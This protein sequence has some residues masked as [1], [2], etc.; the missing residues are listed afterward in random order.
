MD[1]DIANDTKFSSPMPAIGLYMAV[2]TLVC[3]ILMLCD[4]F[5]AIL[6]KKPWIPCRFFVLNSFTLTLLSIATKLPSDLTTSMP[7]ACD[8]LSKL[9]GTSLMC[10]SIGFFRPSTVNMSQ[11][12]LS[13]NLAS[14][15][16]MVITIV[17]NVSLQ[18]STGAIFLFKLENVIVLVLML[19]LL[20]V[21]GTYRM[22]FSDYFT[23]P[24]RK[25]L[26]HMP[27][28]VYTLKRCYVHSYITDP[29]LTL[30]RLSSSATVGVLCTICFAVLSEAAVRAFILDQGLK[31]DSDY[32]WSIWVVVGLQLITLLVGTL[33]NVCRGLALASQMHS[34]I[35]I[36][37]TRHTFLESQRVFLLTHRNWNLY[38]KTLNRSRMVFQI[39]RTMENI[40]DSLLFLMGIWAESVNKLILVPIRMVKEFFALAMEKINTIDCF[41]LLEGFIDDS[42]DDKMI[43]KL[44]SEFEDDGHDKYS[45]SIPG[46]YSEYLLRKSVMDMEMR[47]KKHSTHPM[48]SLL[49][50][51]STTADDGSVELLKQISSSSDELVLLVCL[52]RMADSLASSLRI[53]PLASA[54][55]QAFEIIVFIHAKTITKNVDPKH[56]ANR[57]IGSFMT[58][59]MPAE[60]E[61]H[62]AVGNY[63]SLGNEETVSD[64]NVIKANGTNVTEIEIV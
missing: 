30:C 26:Q 64:A 13:A 20:C 53:V 33:A 9:C 25:S 8:Q 37:L 19:L 10:I 54:L 40:L 42:N 43:L 16:I 14:L 58:T 57:N 1:V 2:A 44:K 32:K 55:D 61:N 21:M 22:I 31:G 38:L 52:V 6:R 11:S 46:F 28:N 7:S 24:F 36:A 48:T 60:R 27:R 56:Y 4:I 29:Q 23:E 5:N 51:L 3:L 35:L 59:D 15:S 49:E 18:I 62:E 47:I 63:A 45:S 39:F 41:S 50:F 17:V 12:E 34:F